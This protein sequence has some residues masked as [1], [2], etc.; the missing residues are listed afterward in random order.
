MIADSSSHLKFWFQ[1]DLE[2]ETSASYYR[3]GKQL[4]NFSPWSCVGHSLRPMCILWL[5]KIWQVSSS[6][7]LMQHLETCFLIAGW[8]WQSCVS[9]CDVFNCP[10]PLDAPNEMKGFSVIGFLVEKCAACQSHRKSDFGWH[11]FVFHLAW[12]VKGLKS[13]KRFWPYSRWFSGAAS[14]LVSLSNYK[15][16]FMLFFFWFREVERR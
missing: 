10:F 7:K 2:H 11:R 16:Y 4:L 9:S 3:Q 8:S 5:V 14:R 15:L 13:L 12:C 6:G 1:T